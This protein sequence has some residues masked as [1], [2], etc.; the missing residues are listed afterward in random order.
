VG[1]TGSKMLDMVARRQ[2]ESAMKVP[3]GNYHLVGELARQDAAILSGYWSSLR[4]PWSWYDEGP[5]TR[6]GRERR[7]RPGRLLAVRDGM[8]RRHEAWKGH[9]DTVVHQP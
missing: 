3:T 9:H 7:V 5:V 4:G 6:L 8:G 1:W 2:G